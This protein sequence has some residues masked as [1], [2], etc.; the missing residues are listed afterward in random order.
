MSIGTGTRAHNH[1]TITKPIHVESGV[2][3]VIEKTLSTV[4]P[5]PTFVV[6]TI[7][8]GDGRA[9]PSTGSR[10]AMPTIPATIPATIAVVVAGAVGGCGVLDSLADNACEGS[11]LSPPEALVSALCSACPLP[12]VPLPSLSRSSRGV[13][14]KGTRGGTTSL[15]AVM[16]IVAETIVTQNTITQQPGNDTTAVSISPHTIIA[17]PNPTIIV[18]HLI[19]ISAAA[20]ASYGDVAV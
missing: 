17:A 7:V 9:A 15:P 8:D 2:V 20:I 14:V 1:Q 13:G 12:R 5:T 4:P 6:K 10:S 19:T 18:P 11:S 3:Q 16:A